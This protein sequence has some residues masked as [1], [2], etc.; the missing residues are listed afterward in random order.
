MCAVLLPPGVNPI[1]VKYIHHVISYHIIS[2]IMY[3]II[4]N[5]YNI[6]YHIYHFC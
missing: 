6:I 5:I 3:H 4:Y 1:A 2:Y